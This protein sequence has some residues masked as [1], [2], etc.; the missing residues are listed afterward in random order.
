MSAPPQCHDY[1][2]YLT[3]VGTGPLS[4]VMVMR[5]SVVVGITQ[6]LPLGEGP[7]GG[8][9]TRGGEEEVHCVS[10]ELDKRWRIVTETSIKAKSMKGY[11]TYTR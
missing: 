9:G 1:E 5:A 8:Q 10:Q 2:Q 4:R 7:N 11:A 6:V 3:A